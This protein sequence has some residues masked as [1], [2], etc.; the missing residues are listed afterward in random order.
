[1]R[2]RRARVDRK[3]GRAVAGD[4]PAAG[5]LQHLAGAGDVCGKGLR[6][7]GEYPRVVPAVAGQFVPGIDDAPHQGAVARRHPAQREERRLDP[8]SSVKVEHGL[9]VALDTG[10]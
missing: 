1:M 3:A 5:I 7:K 4:G 9:A 2:P 10:G 8:R 6:A